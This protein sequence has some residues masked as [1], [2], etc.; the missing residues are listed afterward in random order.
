MS[1]PTAELKGHQPQHEYLV[2]IDSDGC[3]FDTME[4]KHKECFI[5]NIVKHWKLQAVSKYARMAAEFVNLYSKWRGVNRFP[6]LTMAFDL[7]EDWDKVQERGVAI[8][9]APNLRRWIETESKLGNPAL[10]A[11][12]KEHPDQ[13]DMQQALRWSKAVN[14]TVADMVE[15]VP[16]F[17][18]VRESLEKAQ[19]RADILVCS[20]TPEE[21]LRKEWREHDVDGYP[22]TIAGQEQGKKAEHIAYASQG[23]YEASHILMIGDA[24][25]DM[26]AARA[27]NAL[28]YPIKPGEEDVSWKRLHD[29][30]LDRFLNGTYAGEYEQKLID[31]FEAVLP[32]TPPW[33]QSARG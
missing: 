13:E 2:A 33:K 16:P 20:A 7:L 28:F 25:G 24:P 27:N 1:D 12:C 10:E 15:G 18:H 5:P 22:F 11:Y 29:E 3:V 9:K 32:D 8:P 26:K 6:A 30:A 17:P 19:Q 23:R 4:I 21:A 14:D 31:E